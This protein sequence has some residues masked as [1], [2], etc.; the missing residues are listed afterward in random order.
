MKKIEYIVVHCSANSEGSRLRVTDID[1][2]HRSLGWNGC[3]YHY[4][5][6]TDG[7]IEVGRA[8]DM[9]GAHCAKHNTH[10]IGVCYIG[11]LAADGRTPKDTRTPEQKA[12]MRK[13]LERLH[14][15]YPEALIVGH[16]NLEP[17]KPCCPGFDV[18]KEYQD[19]KP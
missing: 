18:A 6:P 13:L 11:G 17:K 4:V 3:G 1:R 19:L 10:S 2:Y 9:T 12:A 14:R 16:C 15:K 7:T 5:I 8:E